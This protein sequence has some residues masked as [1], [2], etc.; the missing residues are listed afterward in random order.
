MLFGL[1]LSFLLLSSSEM[2]ISFSLFF[3][4]WHIIPFC[5]SFSLQVGLVMQENL[6]YK[7]LYINPGNYSFHLI[8]PLFSVG[9]QSPL[10][11][12]FASNLMVEFLFIRVFIVE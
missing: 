12:S 7:V 9:L 2:F 3:F 11:F 5:N 6:E 4:F 10:L 1:L 8:W